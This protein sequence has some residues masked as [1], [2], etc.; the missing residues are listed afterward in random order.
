MQKAIREG[1]LKEC[2]S[3]RANGWTLIDVEVADREWAGSTDYLRHPKLRALGAK[4]VEDALEALG[5]PDLNDV[6][7]LKEAALAEEA[8]IR[9]RE[10]M[11]E[12]VDADEVGHARHGQG[13]HAREAIFSIPARMS[14][15][16]AA[17]TDK[18]RV[19]LILEEALHEALEELAVEALAQEIAEDAKRSQS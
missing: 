11:G 15:E 2:L 18:K 5:N 6:R 17:E 3:K 16:L 4:K 12:L 13:R 9:V 14:S 10:R 19:E 1:R 7:I 8:R